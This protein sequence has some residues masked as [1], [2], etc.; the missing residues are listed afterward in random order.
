MILLLQ[1]A[2]TVKVQRT[3]A[4]D[5]KLHRVK[6]DKYRLLVKGS[7]PPSGACCGAHDIRV[8]Q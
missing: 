2:L 4:V 6:F 3:Y 1:A 8:Y 5:E 7:W